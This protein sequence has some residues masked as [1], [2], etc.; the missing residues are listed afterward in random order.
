MRVE[1]DASRG[2]ARRPVEGRQGRWPSEHAGRLASQ[3][4]AA[5]AAASAAAVASC[6]NTLLTPPHACSRVQQPGPPLFACAPPCS[7]TSADEHAVSTLRHGPCSP[8]TNDMRPAA[9]DTLSPVTAYTEPR[10]DGGSA[11]AQSIGARIF[12]DGTTAAIT[13]PLGGKNLGSPRLSGPM[14][15]RFEE[16]GSRSRVPSPTGS[17]RW[18]IAEVIEKLRVHG[19]G[20][21]CP[22][23][24]GLSARG[25][26][27]HQRAHPQLSLTGPTHHRGDSR[28]LSRGCRT[29]F[30]TQW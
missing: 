20:Q 12:D 3:P 27:R 21:R 2:E 18:R 13:P 10:A 22:K 17:G 14:G 25:G 4:A 26:A 1:R 15:T 6:D 30:R 5:A 11:S 16:L 9:T 29:P 7:A 23:V 24:I 8:S 28:S 19:P